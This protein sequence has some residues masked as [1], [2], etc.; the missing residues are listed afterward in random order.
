MKPKQIP[1]SFALW[2]KNQLVNDM[3]IDKIDV[4]AYY[5]HAITVAENKTVFTQKFGNLFKPTH[6]K[7]TKAEQ[8]EVEKQHILE[9]KKAEYSERF[10]I[11]IKMV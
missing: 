5:D 6:A 8:K 10:G 1:K 4:T 7:L 2:L 3:D 9:S 11:E